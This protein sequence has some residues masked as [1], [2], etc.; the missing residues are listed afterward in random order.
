MNRIV[1]EQ[2]EVDDTPIEIITMVLP[3]S[4]IARSNVSESSNDL[5]RCVF[6]VTIEGIELP[7]VEAP[8]GLTV[9]ISKAMDTSTAYLIR[10]RIR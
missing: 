5:Q 7:L 4:G 6:V 8:N 10:P 3:S 9:Y 1:S 2:A